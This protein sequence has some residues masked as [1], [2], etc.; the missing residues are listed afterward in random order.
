MTLMFYKVVQRLYKPTMFCYMNVNFA[1]V[2]VFIKNL[3]YLLCYSCTVRYLMFAYCKFT[4][5][6][7][8]EGILKVVNIWLSYHKR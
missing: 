7:V 3:T 5:M 1:S 6:S 8:G 2:K 4:A